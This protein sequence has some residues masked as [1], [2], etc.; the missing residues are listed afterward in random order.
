MGKTAMQELEYKI[1]E[2]LDSFPDEDELSLSAR[3]SYDAYVNCLEWV[4]FSLEQE[5]QQI[6]TAYSKGLTT[7]G[8]NG[9]TSISKSLAEQYYNQQ[10]KQ[11]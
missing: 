10:F 4:R 8:I 5:K 7:N 6:I 11:D 2:R 9:E 1:Q 3:G